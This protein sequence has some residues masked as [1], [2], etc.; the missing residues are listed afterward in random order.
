M[1][2]IERIAGGTVT[3]INAFMDMFANVLTSFDKCLI[4]WGG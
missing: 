4:F 2:A 1:I 3:K